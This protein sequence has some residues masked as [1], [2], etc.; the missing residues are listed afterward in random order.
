MNA[1][2]VPITA[3]GMARYGVKVL[4]VDAAASAT[5]TMIRLPE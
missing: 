1:I 4:C 5:A 3:S 2:A